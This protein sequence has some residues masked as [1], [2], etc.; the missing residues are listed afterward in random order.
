MVLSRGL[1]KEM[2]IEES[3]K[4]GLSY[5]E[6]GM[7]SRPS[8][9]GNV[10]Q[11]LVRSRR[12][13]T[14]YSVEIDTEDPFI[15]RCSCPYFGAGI[16]KHIVALG[17]T[18]L[19]RPELFK[20]LR[21]NNQKTLAKDSRTIDDKEDNER[22]RVS[23]EDYLKKMNTLKERSLTIV[24][25]LNNYGGLSGETMDQ[26][27]EWMEEL[28]FFLDHREDIPP[29]TRKGIID[30]FLDEL[31]KMNSGL[32]DHVLQIIVSAAK[33]HWERTYIRDILLRDGSSLLLHQWEEILQE[34]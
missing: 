34:E 4:R 2:A 7:V 18:Y 1:L 26:C 22:S 17:L 11:A 5:Y 27:I 10:I 32:E 25:D 21:E 33:T 28:V 20:T 29:S 23:L 8:I 15:H 9:Y 16:C 14:H 30:E 3:F 6:R 13:N 31:L 19:R 24:E 12:D